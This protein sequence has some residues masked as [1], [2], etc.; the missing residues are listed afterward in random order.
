MSNSDKK[1]TSPAEERA[2]L[3]DDFIKR[4]GKVEKIPYGVTSQDLGVGNQNAYWLPPETISPK[5]YKTRLTKA[6]KKAKNKK[7][8]SKKKKAK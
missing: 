4:G 7:S 6:K 5:T 8:T 1:P 3:L 2:K